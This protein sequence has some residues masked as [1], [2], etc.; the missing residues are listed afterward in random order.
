MSPGE[1]HRGHEYLE[2]AKE[3]GRQNIACKKKRGFSCPQSPSKD[4][5]NKEFLKYKK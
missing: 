5:I 4:L 2:Q 1:W 3:I